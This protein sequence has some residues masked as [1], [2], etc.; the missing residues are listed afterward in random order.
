MTTFLIP[1]LAPTIGHNGEN[2]TAKEIVAVILFYIAIIQMVRIIF[3]L[4][5]GD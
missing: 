5:G 4:F 3:K 2:L 1:Y